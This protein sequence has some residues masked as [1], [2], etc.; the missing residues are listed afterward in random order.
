MVRMIIPQHLKG[1]MMTEESGWQNAACHY[2]QRHY[3]GYG[4]WMGLRNLNLEDAKELSRS[5]RRTEYL[6]SMGYSS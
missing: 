4:L 6:D 2:P 1:D 5:D 3:Q